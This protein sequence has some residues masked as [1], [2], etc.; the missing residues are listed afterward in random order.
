MSFTDVNRGGTFVKNEAIAA[1]LDPYFHES[2][3]KRLTIK[4]YGLSKLHHAELSFRGV[5][6]FV[7]KMEK[8]TDVTWNRPRKQLETVYV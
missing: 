3:L 4:S 1:F 2:G 8:I 6:L 7:W 5:S